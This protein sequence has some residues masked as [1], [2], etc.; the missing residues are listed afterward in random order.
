[1]IYICQT[2]GKSYKKEP[3]AKRKYCSRECYLNRANKKLGEQ[4]SKKHFDITCLECGKV[5]RVPPAGTNRKYCSQKCCKKH[6]RKTE[7]HKCPTCEKLFTHNPCKF[8]NGTTFCSIKC[9]AES[10]RENRKCSVCG[11]EFH[12]KK[13]A[14]NKYC[15]RECFNESQKT[16]VL[17][18]CSVCGKVFEK[19]P[20]QL[21]VNG[22]GKYCSMECSTEARKKPIELVCHTCGKKYIAA[23]SDIKGG[24]GKYCSRE[25][26]KNQDILETCTCLNCGKSFEYPKSQI[27]KGRG[28]YCSKECSMTSTLRTENFQ[29]KRWEHLHVNPIRVR[30]IGK[31]ELG[32][33]LKGECN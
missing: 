29:Q 20:S 3:S 25:C 19:T 30:P 18:V 27:K 1:M 24:R 16:S 21:K 6:Q 2:C 11:K 23:P 12:I 22:A 33:L 14:V 7:T 8:K 4:K 31:N 26:F 10:H 17:K 9:F 15:S 5:F 28:K 32:A 13:S